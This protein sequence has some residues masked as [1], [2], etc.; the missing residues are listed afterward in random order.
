MGKEWERIAESRG[1]DL[2]TI[3]ERRRPVTYN[4]QSWVCLEQGALTCLWKIRS[5]PSSDYDG[6]S[7]ISGL[8]PYEFFLH[9]VAAKIVVS[10]QTLEETKFHMYPDGSL[11]ARTPYS[12]TCKDCRVFP[13]MGSVW[14]SQNGQLKASPIQL[15]T[16]S[17][18]QSV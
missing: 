17:L 7:G 10:Q 14:M 6:E 2:R 16:S 18:P 11:S 5:G 9:S 8:T 1:L 13:L 12:T 4:Q 3:N 15:T